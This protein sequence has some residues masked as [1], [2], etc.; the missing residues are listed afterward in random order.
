MQAYPYPYSVDLSQTEEVAI[1][2]R[3][4]WWED[5]NAGAG[6]ET[7]IHYLGYG[8]GSDVRSDV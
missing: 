1:D 5:L 6:Y 7:C 2:E 4:R 3:V 8:L